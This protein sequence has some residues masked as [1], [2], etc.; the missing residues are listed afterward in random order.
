MINT[1]NRK[2]EP[3]GNPC[4][5]DASVDAESAEKNI[6]PK[7]RQSRSK[8]GSK[9]RTKRMDAA[10]VHEQIAGVVK[11]SAA[12]IAEALIERALDGDTPAA[13]Y[14]F[15]FAQIFPTADQTNAEAKEEDSLAKT[16][17]HR[18]NL[19]DEPI[20]IDDDED[21]KASASATTDLAPGSGSAEDEKAAD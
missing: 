7:K 13:K 5:R 12:D 10:K 14:L 18:L 1:I 15:E 6:A 9:T 19:P 8:T 21:G 16:L 20:K 3:V 2:S 11:A 4:D 17:M